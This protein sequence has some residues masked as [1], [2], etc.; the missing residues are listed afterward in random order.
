MSSE[1]DDASVG[2]RASV[3]VY[4]F[5]TDAPSQPSIVSDSVDGEAIGWLALG[6]L[7][8]NPADP[9]TI[10][11]ASDV[12]LKPSTIFTVDVTGAPARITDTLVVTKNGTPQ[13]LDIEG[14]F[15]RPAGG[16]WL[17]NEGATGAGNSLVRTDAAGAVT[18]TVALPAE[19]TAQI[20]RWG[21]EGVTATTDASGSE[22][23]WVA[24][25]RPLWTNPTAATGPLDGEGVT[26]IGR[27]DTTTGEWSWFGYQLESTGVA[28]DWM[29]LSE[30]VAV[31]DDTL[32]V[33]ERDKLNGPKAAIKRVYTVEVPDGAGV[34]GLATP[35]VL[36]KTL[37]IDVLPA[38]QSVNG[39]TQEKL[40]GLTI[41]ADGEVYA[42]TDN[43]GLINATGETV[44]LRLGSAAELF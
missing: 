29:G 36:D 17:A 9:G 1:N 31:D 25:Q 44:F 11:A 32:A 38:L 7:S 12:A 6:A 22:I 39:W 41:G 33:I 26:R 35:T 2:V 15:A 20:G 3:N 24:V 23:V 16:Y 13:N 30:I 42:V 28:G 8:A 40:E 21:L 18:E 5:G 43:D 4:E 34:T 27:Y 37:A 14:L 19:V 10:F